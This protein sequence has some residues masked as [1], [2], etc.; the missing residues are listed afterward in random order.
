MPLQKHSVVQK[1]YP[2]VAAF[3]ASSPDLA[4]FR[5]F[6]ELNVRNLLYLQTELIVLESELETLD[7]EGSATACGADWRRSWESVL[8]G[9]KEEDIVRR[10]LVLEIRAKLKEYSKRSISN[11]PPASGTFAG[12]LTYQTDEA[13]VL[14]SKVLALE[15]PPNR[16]LQA[17]EHWLSEHGHP[18]MRPIIDRGDEFLERA[19]D[20]AALAG[21]ERLNDPLSNFLKD[22]SGSLLKVRQQD[23]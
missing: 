19:Q 4:V 17:F 13:L 7:G 22:H 2:S 23:S 12:L 8:R 14:H 5:R 21:S 18:A 1:G 10:K 11:L 3:I 20:L 16:A 9:Q 15:E 6:G